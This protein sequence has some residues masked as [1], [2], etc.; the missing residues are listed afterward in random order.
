MTF[1]AARARIFGRGGEAVSR[2]PHKPE[3]ACSTQARATTLMRIGAMLGRDNVEAIERHVER[4]ERKEA[5]SKRSREIAKAKRL[6]KTI[7]YRRDG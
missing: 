2:W 5:E 3:I 4:G 1:Y 7:R 6:G